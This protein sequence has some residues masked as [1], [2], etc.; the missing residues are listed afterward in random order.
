[1]IQVL[2]VDDQALMRSGF[3]MILEA[4]PDITVAGEARDGVEAV[5]EALRL[6]PQV[7]LMDVRM[8]R[9]DGIEAT[10]QILASAASDTRVL[11]LTMF[12]LD[13]FVYGALTAG[14]SGFLLKDATPEQLVMA[15]RTVVGGDQL[16]A[17]VI[18][19]RLIEQYIRRPLPSQLRSPASAATLTPRELD[20]IRQ[21]SQGNSNAETALELGIGESTV[22]THVANIL[23][24]LGLADR[25]QI[26]I[27]AYEHGL[28][29]VS[30][31]HLGVEGP[32][33]QDR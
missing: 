12:D 26:V 8:P 31:S 21:V 23:A 9:L 3:R 4:Q 1:V 16:L 5:A 7:V 28:T 33:L 18:T 13:E 24:K 32:E 14:A 10:R 11:V 19:R 29:G 6:R 20:V 17:P 25:V 30:R 15:V 22:K 2:V 27:F